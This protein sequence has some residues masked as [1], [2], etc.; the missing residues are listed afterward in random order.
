VVDLAVV[1]LAGIDSSAASRARAAVAFD[2]S[3]STAGFAV[4]V[5]HGIHPR[6]VARTFDALRT[7]FAGPA[8]SKQAVASGSDG[9]GYAAASDA[10]AGAETFVS[11]PGHDPRRAPNRWPDEMVGF[12]ETLVAYTGAAAS[13]VDR[14]ALLGALALGHDERAAAPALGRAGLTLR[15]DRHV[16]EAPPGVPPIGSGIWL[17]VVG[18]DGVDGLE[19]VDRAG[20]WRGVSTPR[21]SLVVHAGPMFAGMSGGRWAPS[22]HRVAGLGTSRLAVA[23]QLSSDEATAGV[24]RQVGASRVA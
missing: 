3:M 23:L 15:A 11:H 14:L 6:L 19:L 20:S 13:L 7:F 18:V 21:G 24:D 4:V 22:T 8:S 10:A 16:G 12:R 17:T 9:L 2:G 1:D 5:R